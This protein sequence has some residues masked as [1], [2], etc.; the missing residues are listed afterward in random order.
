MVRNPRWQQAAE[1]GGSGVSSRF[2]AATYETVTPYEA[3]LPLVLAREGWP[4]DFDRLRGRCDLEHRVRVRGQT[5]DVSVGRD[6]AAAV[7]EATMEVALGERAADGFDLRRRRIYLQHGLGVTRHAV[8][9][10]VEPDDTAVPLPAALR[11]RPERAYLLRCGVDLQ[12]SAAYA[13][14][15]GDVRG[16]GDGG[17]RRRVSRES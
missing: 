17:A 15:R 11:H 3:V 7:L 13:H 8:H 14:V 1:H 16:K 9:A 4:H 12:H 5:V 2:N 6:D 10:V